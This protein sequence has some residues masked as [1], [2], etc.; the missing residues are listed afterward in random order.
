MQFEVE[1][2][3]KTVYMRHRH[4]LPRKHPYRNMDKRFDGTR[5]KALPPRYFSEEDVHNQ[6]KNINV[7]LSKRNQS[8]KDD[9]QLGMWSKKSILFELEYWEKLD[10]HHSIGN[11]DV[12]KNICDSLI[13]TLL[14]MK[15]KGKDHENA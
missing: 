15:G 6:V 10:I 11:M 4:F 8:S 7:I 14:Q 2:L 5:K 9:E 1:Q 12:K 3:K 13:G